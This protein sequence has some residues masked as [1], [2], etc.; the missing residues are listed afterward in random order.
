MKLLKDPVKSKQPVLCTKG[1][2]GRIH[3]ETFSNVDCFGMEVTLAMEKVSL[4]LQKGAHYWKNLGPPT[5]GST[6]V[7]QPPL[8]KFSTVVI[9]VIPKC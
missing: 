6:Y 4:D 9:L 2:K 3:M 8:G 5:P 7:A 1:Q